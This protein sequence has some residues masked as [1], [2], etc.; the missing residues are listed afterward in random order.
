MNDYRFPENRITKA[1]LALYLFVMLYL[2][3]DSMFCLSVVG[4]YPSMAV[5][6]GATA[7]VGLAFL[8]HQR[9]NLKAVFLDGRMKVA[10]AVTVLVLAPMV[11]KRDWQFMY[12]SILICMYTAI[13]LSYF[14]SWQALAKYYVGMMTALGVYSILAAYL[15]RVPIDMGLVEKDVFRNASDFGFYNFLFSVVPRTYAKTR[16]FGLFRE[17]GVYQYFILLALFLT[18][19]GVQWKK[20]RTMWVVT[21]ILSVVMISTL[22][23]GGLAELA[24]LAAFVFFDKKLYRNKILLVVVLLILIAL[25]GFL[26]YNYDYYTPLWYQ[27]EVNIVGKFT[28]PGD[29]LFE[30]TES[31]AVNLEILKEHPLVGDRLANVLHVVENN[32]SSSLIL[33][34]V[35]GV[36]SGAFHVLAWGA[37]VWKKERS[38][39]GNLLLLVILFLSF[40]TQNLI[41]DQFFWLF[42]VM[43][44][45]EKSVPYLKGRRKETA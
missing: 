28:R 19:Y 12:V 41:G 20:Q 37:L 2:C 13:L 31:L 38:V 27:I 35:F 43:A 6:L 17:P 22:A 25:P 15:F 16:N 4:F 34:A 7:L 21:A 36:L 39:L 30:R 10:L 45:T 29:S 42:P 26:Y 1:L 40:N 9:G 18:H 8:W 33:F 32:T 3:R 24:L 23:T 44:L 11:L 5:T 14:I